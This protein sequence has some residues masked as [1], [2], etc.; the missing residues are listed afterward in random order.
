MPG[1]AKFNRRLMITLDPETSRVLVDLQELMGKPQATILRDYVRE[2]TPVLGEVAKALKIAQRRPQEAIEAIS[3][4]A[5]EKALDTLQ[6]V[7]PMRRKRGRP[8]KAR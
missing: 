5:T 7:L 4:M 6:M 1:I 8:K 3:G 2:L